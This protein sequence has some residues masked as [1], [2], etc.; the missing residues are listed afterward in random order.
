MIYWTSRIKNLIKE[1][2]LRRREW[3]KEEQKE[4]EINFCLEQ[5]SHSKIPIIRR[6]DSNSDIIT[7]PE[8]TS[9]SI[10]NSSSHHHHPLHSNSLQNEPSPFNKP[11]KTL[12]PPSMMNLSP[13]YNARHMMPRPS[14][15]SIS[16]TPN[17]IGAQANQYHNDLCSIILTCLSWFLV[18]LFFPLS[19][20]FLFRIVQEYERGNS[21]FLLYSIFSALNYTLS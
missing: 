19:L 2:K 16:E 13:H 14:V 12:T 9:N 1:E 4:N 21:I 10:N 6:I 5:M 7:S 15:R 17:V 18:V 8:H 11:M 20:A 3:E